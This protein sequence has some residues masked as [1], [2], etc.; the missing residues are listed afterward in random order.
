M[1]KNDVRAHLKLGHY[2]PQI[3]ESRK[4][5]KKNLISSKVSQF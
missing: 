2:A 3:V 4:S 5:F 1:Q